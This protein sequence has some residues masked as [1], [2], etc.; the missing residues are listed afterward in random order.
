MF[1]DS[2]AIALM[3][4]GKRGKRKLLLVSPND[5]VEMLN[6]LSALG[7]IYKRNDDDGEDE[8]DD[9]DDSPPDNGDPESPPP[10]GKLMYAPIEDEISRFL[11]DITRGDRSR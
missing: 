3:T 6:L 5:L 4:R 1:I 10:E 11:E 2:W 9:D 7:F 8:G